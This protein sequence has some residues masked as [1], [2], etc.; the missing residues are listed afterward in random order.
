MRSKLSESDWKYPQPSCTGHG[1]LQVSPVHRMYY[2]EYG[3]PAG[4]PVL[5]VHGG[6]G[7]ACDPVY[8]RFF[9]PKRYRIVLFDQRGCG[10]STPNAADKDPT[11]A[12][13]DNTTAH[14]IADINA[15]RE[16]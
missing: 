12:L 3:N 1:H 16:H 6:P 11:P 4:E 10:N 7:G 13:D 5:V 14:L 8:A 9:D 15:L 2:E